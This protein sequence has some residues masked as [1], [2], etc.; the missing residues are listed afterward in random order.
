M[1]KL[2]YKSKF[3]LDITITFIYRSILL[4]NIKILLIG[5]KCQVYDRFLKFRVISG[6]QA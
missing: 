1:N 2:R 5:I 6:I 4:I 3:Y